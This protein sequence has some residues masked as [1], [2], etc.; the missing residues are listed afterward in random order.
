MRR[1]RSKSAFVLV[2]LLMTIYILLFAKVFLRIFEYRPTVKK[3]FP[4][5]D[6]W[7]D[8]LIRHPQFV[9]QAHRFMKVIGIVVHAVDRLR[10]GR[11]GSPAL[12]ELGRRHVFI[13]GFLPDYFDAFTRAVIYVW[14]Q[15]LREAFSSD[16][17]D[18]WRA[19]FAYIIEQL[20]D[21]YED[22]WRATILWQQPNH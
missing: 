3:M 20:K 1:I 13:E 10:S 2:G 7:G 14:Q 12:Y 15:E 5:R 21:G 9:L 6:A 18:A 19:L 22:D 8:Q 11:G 17:A 16:V 4:F